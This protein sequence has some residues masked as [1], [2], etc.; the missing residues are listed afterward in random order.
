MLKS[1]FLARVKNKKWLTDKQ[2]ATFADWLKDKVGL[3]LFLSLFPHW[4][5]F[6]LINIWR[7]IINFNFRLQWN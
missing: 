3:H 7:L 6:H 2:N 5:C 4:M 1:S